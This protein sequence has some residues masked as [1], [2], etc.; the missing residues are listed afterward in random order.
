MW[1]KDGLFYVTWYVRYCLGLPQVFKLLKLLKVS[2]F[3]YCN[4]TGVRWQLYVHI[5][6]NKHKWGGGV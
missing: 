6:H 2:K 5:T 4:W 3:I 1:E